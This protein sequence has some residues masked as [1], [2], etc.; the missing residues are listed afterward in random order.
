MKTKQFIW[1]LAFIV[2][3]TNIFFTL[4]TNKQTER[5]MF[6]IENLEAYASDGEFS[7]GPAGTNWKEYTIDCTYTETVNGSITVGIPGIV[8]GSIG[9]SS[10]KTWTEYNKKVCGYGMGTCLSSAG[11]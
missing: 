11:C 4:K 10:S 3:G 8:G 7:T 6:T 5:K 9:G 2:L 1:G